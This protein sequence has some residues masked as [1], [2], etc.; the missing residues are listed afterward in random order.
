MEYCTRADREGDLAEDASAISE[1]GWRVY[2]M[3]TITAQPTPTSA[4]ESAAVATHLKST[5]SDKPSQRASYVTTIPTA[6]SA[7]YSLS[8]TGRLLP[9]IRRRAQQEPAQAGAGAVRPH[10]PRCRQQAMRA[11]EV[12][13]SGCACAVPEVLQIDEARGMGEGT[14]METE[15]GRQLS[16]MHGSYGAW[17]VCALSAHQPPKLGRWRFS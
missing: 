8:F 7:A 1:H 10:T 12:R 9:E 4:Y 15:A 16:C 3:L 5:P 14:E 11:Q 6:V 17:M 2:I 13:R